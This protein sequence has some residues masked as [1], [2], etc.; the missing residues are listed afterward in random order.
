MNVK[1]TLRDQYRYI[2][3]RLTL[4]KPQND[5]GIG[6]V[7]RFINK[8][9]TRLT[10]SSIDIEEHIKDYVDFVNFFWP[11]LGSDQHYAVEFYES[12]YNPLAGEQPKLD[13]ILH[14]KTNMCPIDKILSWDIQR[15][16]PRYTEK[17]Y[18]VMNLQPSANINDLDLNKIKINDN[19]K[20]YFWYARMNS[21]RTDITPYLTFKVF[22]KDGSFEERSDCI[23][24]AMNIAGW[25]MIQLSFLDIVKCVESNLDLFKINEKIIDD[26]YNESSKY[27]QYNDPNTVHNI[28]FAVFCLSRTYP[29]MLFLLHKCKISPDNVKKY[30]K[31][32]DNGALETN[33]FNILITT[34]ICMFNDTL[35]ENGLLIALKIY[36]EMKY[37]Y[38]ID[39]IINCTINYIASYGLATKDIIENP[40]VNQAKVVPEVLNK[41]V[42]NDVCDDILGYYYPH[43]NTLIGNIKYEKFDV[44][45][46]LKYPV[47]LPDFINWVTQYAVNNEDLFLYLVYNKIPI[48]IKNCNRQLSFEDMLDFHNI[49]KANDRNNRL[50]YDP[51]HYYRC[52]IFG[53]LPPAGIGQENK[54]NEYEAEEYPGNLSTGMQQERPVTPVEQKDSE[55]KY[56]PWTEKTLIDELEGK[57]GIRK[58]NI[59]EEPHD[60]YLA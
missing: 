5:W 35:N 11:E 57:F 10:N 14:R 32:D 15:T 43:L 38:S 36:D 3:S 49:C 59:V 50:I 39:D 7:Q 4:I 54:I 52:K 27:L 30:I 18:G 19:F 2:Y 21:I 33:D 60:D 46:Y 26:E 17:R 8:K 56:L 40:V 25:Y 53:I 48:E 24:Q 20:R 22:S 37:N 41:S 44:L 51:I 1:E 12:V 13:T 47:L 28:I 55:I 45:G 31:I 58:K 34:L 16:S 42:N 9:L 23:E 6:C 29:I